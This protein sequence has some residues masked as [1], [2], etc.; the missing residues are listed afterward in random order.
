MDYD[1]TER[2]SVELVTIPRNRRMSV[3]DDQT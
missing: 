1:P 3:N 2:K